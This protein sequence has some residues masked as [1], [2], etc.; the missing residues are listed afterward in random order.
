MSND[1]SNIK[2]IAVY[3]RVST[4]E[5]AQEGFSLDGQL[6]KLRAYCV[7]RDWD[8]QGEYVD[9]GYTGTN[10]NR[11]MY[12][13][14][15]KNMDKWD[16]IVVMKMD[17][18]HRNSRNFMEM[19]DLLQKKGKDFI[20][21][22]ES[23]DTST[24]MGRFVMDIIQR[25]AQLES[26]QNGERVTFAMKQKAMTQGFVGH[27]LAF[28][29]KKL[30]DEIIEI[31]EQLEIIKIVFKLYADGKSMGEI[32]KITGKPWGSIRY[33]L[34]NIWYLGYEQWGD[35]FKLHNLDPVVS[36]DLWNMAQQQK[37]SKTGRTQKLKPFILDELV[38]S[39]TL[40]DKEMREYGFSMDIPKHK[41]GN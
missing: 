39:F 9:D 3:T 23:L 10:K 31:P 41:I 32:E 26:E 33:W 8:I 6:R 4:V 25:I 27:R 30:K 21:N 7:S 16:A 18:I 35:C 28:G 12:K 15:I 1:D 29:Y 34:N 22:T 5:Q 24:A 17:R 36:L 19:M 40:T 11:P 37:R 14:M 13:E 20:S 2:T 38:D